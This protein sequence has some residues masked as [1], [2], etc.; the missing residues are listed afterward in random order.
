MDGERKKKVVMVAGRG[1]SQVGWTRLIEEI[2]KTL[3][4]FIGVIIEIAWLAPSQP[5]TSPLPSYPPSIDPSIR[6]D[7]LNR[8]VDA[9]ANLIGSTSKSHPI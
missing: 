1:R 5:F 3:P 8:E 6:I 9:D 4:C 7:K 2:I